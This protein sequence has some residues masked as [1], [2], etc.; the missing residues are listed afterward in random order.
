[1]QFD[2]KE[3][4]GDD[5][6]KTKVDTAVNNNQVTCNK[7]VDDAIRDTKTKVAYDKNVQDPLSYIE[8][9]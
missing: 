9:K 6:S 5:F 8:I 4:V 2:F 3:V 1:M 7:I